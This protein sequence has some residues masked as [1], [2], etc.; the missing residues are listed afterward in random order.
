FGAWCRAVFSARRKVLPG[1]LRD[2]GMTRTAA[3]DA[4]RT[5]GIDPTRRLENLDADEL[6][7]LHRAIQ[8]PLS[9]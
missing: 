1:A 2:A 7:A 4:C 5:C 8:S 9:S 3:E 6:L